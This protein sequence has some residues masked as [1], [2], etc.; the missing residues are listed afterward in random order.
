M[1]VFKPFVGGEFS[2]WHHTL[3]LLPGVNVNGCSHNSQYL[4]AWVW[5]VHTPRGTSQRL[6]FFGYASTI[7]SNYAWRLAMQC[8]AVKNGCLPVL[9][10]ISNTACT[11]TR[12]KQRLLQ[13]PFLTTHS[14]NFCL[15]V[16][17]KA[18]FN[19]SSSKSVPS[20]SS[21]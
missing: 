5:S 1:A 13:C 15:I 19:S 4:Q 12:M 6:T 2:T 10:N 8:C 14:T 20:S 16:N 17:T 21:I 9:V 3:N 18:L 7:R 11:F